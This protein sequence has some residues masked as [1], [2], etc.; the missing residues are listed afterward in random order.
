[1]TAGSVHDEKLKPECWLTSLKI[2]QCTH[3]IFKTTKESQIMAHI[4]SNKKGC[5]LLLLLIYNKGDQ[6]MMVDPC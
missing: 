1:M 3:K 4:I 2:V 5:F 6:R